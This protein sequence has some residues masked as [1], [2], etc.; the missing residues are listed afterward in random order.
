MLAGQDGLNFGKLRRIGDYYIRH[1]AS[2]AMK[3]TEP[4]DL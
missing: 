1:R 2:V 3:L 4:I